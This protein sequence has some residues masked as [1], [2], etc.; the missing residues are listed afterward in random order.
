MAKGRPF[1]F[2][3]P[4]DMTPNNPGM[5]INSEQILGLYN[6]EHPKDQ[7]QRVVTKV[8]SWFEEQAISEQWDEVKFAG[9]QCLLQNNAVAE[10][11]KE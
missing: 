3:D 5:I 4:N 1:V 9:N 10:C 7:M 2:P 11:K 8:R 6:Q